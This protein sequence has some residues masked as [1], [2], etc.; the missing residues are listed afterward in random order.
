VIDYQSIIKIT[1]PGNWALFLEKNMENYVFCVKELLDRWNVPIVEP[2]LSIEDGE[3]ILNLEIYLNFTQTDA[4]HVYIQGL[5]G[6]SRILKNGKTYDIVDDPTL[7]DAKP[8]VL[9][10]SHDHPINVHKVA[11]TKGEPFA[12]RTRENQEKHVKA[13][14]RGPGR[15]SK[16]NS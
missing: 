16:K 1:R 10:S 2:V 7:R 5:H 13:S 15:Y 14:P 11:T 12:A 9:R 6:V 3:I 4:M 8:S